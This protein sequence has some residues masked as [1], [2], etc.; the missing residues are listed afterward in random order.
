VWAV[1][2]IRRDAPLLAT[3]LDLRG[4]ATCFGASTVILGSW[5]AESVAVCDTAGPHSKTVDKIVTAEGAT[6]LDDNLM[7]ISSPGRTCRPNACTLQLLA[8]IFEIGYWELQG[9]ADDCPGQGRQ[10]ARG[11]LA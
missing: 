1:D 3:G 7:T 4:L 11:L 10:G 9:F 6:K 8:E 5:E 2:D